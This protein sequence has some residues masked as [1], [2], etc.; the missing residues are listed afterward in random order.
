MQRLF[1]TCL[2]ILGVVVGAAALRGPHV[3]AEVEGPPGASV[4]APVTRLAVV[5]RELVQA[6]RSTAPQRIYTRSAAA[7]AALTR[8]RQ[9]LSASGA[10]IENP[11]GE[12]GVLSCVERP[13]DAF[14]DQLDALDE[15]RARRHA[16]V[17]ALGNSLIAA[18]GIVDVVRARLVQRF[19][20][21]GRG[22]LLADRI[23]ELA[24]R[25]RTGTGDGFTPYYL[26]QGPRGP[27]PFGLSG[28]AHVADRAGAYTRFSVAGETRASVWLPDTAPDSVAV[29]ADGVKLAP[30]SP[31][32]G[33]VV[34]VALPPGAEDL[35]VR[36]ERPGAV[37]QGVVLEQELPGVVLDTIGLPAA[38][39]PRWL[40]ADETLVKAQ[41]AARDPSLLMVMLG[42]VENRRIAWGR[43][44]DDDIS[45]ALTGLLARLKSGA[46]KASCLVV[47]PID[48]VEGMLDE[49]VLGRKVRPFTERQELTRIIA[50]E[51]RVALESGC[52]FFDLFAAM[53]GS[54]SLQRFSRHGLLHDDHVHP[55]GFGL[56]VLGELIADALLQEW[57]ST[58][59]DVPRRRIA[60]ALRAEEKAA[61]PSLEQT[62]G[63]LAR[64][65]RGEQRQV[66]FG[67]VDDSGELVA[68]LRA[69]LSAALGPTR[70][71]LD[72]RGRLAELGVVVEPAYE[73]VGY[74]VVIVASDEPHDDGSHPLV[75]RLGAASDG[76]AESLTAALLRRL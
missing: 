27:S 51:R 20:D 43:Y 63:L 16:V 53:G 52:A 9:T 32:P 46:P 17:I 34:E 4:R 59:A 41:L 15:G 21:G 13:L 74:D 56:D 40:T 73:G 6:L 2:V 38:D 33:G 11:C 50:L 5:E 65:V 22:L 45:Q 48:A 66:T 71:G 72:R 36:A 35:M 12:R 37:V 68:R 26:S 24:L 58:A 29:L 1:G 57:R 25:R 64:L 47:G 42:G 39:S 23:S 76:A 60:R 8:A 44:S 54:G 55:R 28:V 62:A 14:F 70:T 10:K 31:K 3:A 19:A 18:D 69:S 75:V 7:S 30:T 61:P 67:V 49:R